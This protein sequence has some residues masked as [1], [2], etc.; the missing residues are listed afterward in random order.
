MSTE[1]TDRLE[2]LR[3]QLRAECISTGELIELQGLAGFIEPG[4]VELLEAA[5]VPEHADPMDDDLRE[6]VKLALQGDSN[7][8]EHDALAAVAAAFAIEYINPDEYS[9]DEDDAR[10]SRA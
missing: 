5:G 9:D 3:S 1:H 6:Q 7:D 10:R 4:D 8:D 2:Y